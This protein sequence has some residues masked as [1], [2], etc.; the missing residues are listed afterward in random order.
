MKDGSTTTADANGDGCTWMTHDCGPNS[1]AFNFHGNGVHM[2]FCDGHVSYMRESLS[3]AILR[4]LATRA[5][6]RNEA[7]VSESGY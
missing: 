4:A 1:E 5:D 6:G 3:T 7:E 2:V